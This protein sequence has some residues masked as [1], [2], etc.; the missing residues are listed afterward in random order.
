MISS[1]G[2]FLR[3]AGFVYRRKNFKEYPKLFSKTVDIF[4]KS[5]KGILRRVRAAAL[6]DSTFQAI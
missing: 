5:C 2:P 1:G 6:E 4:I 3:P